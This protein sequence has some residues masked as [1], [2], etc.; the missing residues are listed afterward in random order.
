MGR[1][2]LSVDEDYTSGPA[3]LEWLNYGRHY[4][5]V[6]AKTNGMARPVSRGSEPGYSALVISGIPH[7]IPNCS[8]PLIEPGNM[9]RKGELLWKG[10]DVSGDCVFVEKI[11]YRFL[12]PRRG[13]IVVFKTDG[14]K[15]LQKDTV[16]VNRLVGLP[17]ETI[18]IKPPFLYVN[19]KKVVEPEIFQ[20]K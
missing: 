2:G 5:E 7:L 9:V 14:I 16:Y 1:Y 19:G 6:R 13:E 17:G 10:L 12:K 8:D 18:S 11:S 4:V 20:F 15:S 3:L